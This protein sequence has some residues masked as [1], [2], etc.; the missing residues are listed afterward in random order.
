MCLYLLSNF[1]AFISVFMTV[2]GTEVLQRER[3]RERASVNKLMT[4][5]FYTHS[6]DREYAHSCEL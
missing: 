4:Q 5:W 1:Q 2:M 3:E 6:P